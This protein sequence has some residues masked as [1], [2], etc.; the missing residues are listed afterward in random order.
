V[1]SGRSVP[2]NQIVEESFDC[3]VTG[4]RLSLRFVPEA[5]QD[6]V[7]NALVLTGAESAH[8]QPLFKTAPPP[9][10]PAR[11]VVAATAR[12]DPAAA[13]REICDWLLTQRQAN[14]FLGDTW[15][16][17]VHLWYTASMP[18][19]A[20]L[21]ASE[22]LEEPAYRDAAFQVL[23]LFVEEQLPNGAFSPN[24]RGRPTTDLTADEIRDIYATHGL[25]L[26]DTGSTVSAVALGA[27]YADS[28]RK[29][30]YVESV[31]AF[32]MDWAAG[33]QLPSGAFTDGPG[34]GVYSCATAIQAA[35]FSLTG[36]LTGEA[37]FADHA[38]RAL[39]FL[40]QD[41]L[42]DGRMTGRAPYWPVR[43]QLPFVMETLYFGDQW[44]YDE[45]FITTAH[46]TPDEDLRQ[47][48]H[49]ALQRRVFGRCG[50][51]AALGDGAWWPVQDIWNNA[52]SLGMVQTLL[53]AEESG[54]ETPALRA[55]LA[56][57]RQVVST[58]E[59]SRRL[60]VRAEDS[61]YPA[62]QHGFLTW[63]GMSREATGFAGMTLAEIL[64]PGILYRAVSR[65]TTLDP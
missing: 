65:P 62:E 42:E 25:R 24:L 59:Y 19:R 5:G 27:K 60:G 22:L 15:E 34:T 21:A 17:G 6:L 64:S 7:M 55:V 13:L 54:L 31:R 61:E 8:L 14:G 44:Y 12:D 16:A 43:N 18:V 9:D 37:R 48:I 20:L 47:A 50:L 52:K 51:L 39:R 30:R 4:D 63:S 35:T 45:G 26:S 32:C 46:L 29:A 57:L 56:S 11:A 2:A 28:A 49:E 1:L 41:W 36:A 3:T 38:A 10:M 58:P 33:F 40:L 23:D 53:F